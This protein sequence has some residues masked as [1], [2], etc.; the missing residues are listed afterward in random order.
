M[1]LLLLLPFLVGCGP[2]EQAELQKALN[3]YAELSAQ[4]APLEGVLTGEALKSSLKSADLLVA[5]GLTQ[6]GKAI[7]EVQAAGEGLGIG[8]LDMSAVELINS[9]GERVRPIRPSRV[10]F[11]AQ[12]EENFL[13]SSLAIS[14]KKC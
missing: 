13:I 12:Y 14:D 5:V 8:C 11:E 6:Q 10:E 1:K 7:F 3:Q 4:S 2:S 9:Q